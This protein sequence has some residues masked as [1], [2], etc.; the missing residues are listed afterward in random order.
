MKT[1]LVLLTALALHVSAAP[2]SATLQK[3]LDA[4]GN[5]QNFVRYDDDY[6]YLGF[7]AYKRGFEDPRL[8][9]PARV[10]AVPFADPTKKIKLETLD[11]AVDAITVDGTLYILTF[12]GIEE[13]DARTLTRRAVHPTYLLPGE[14]AYKEHAQAF[15]RAGDSLVI[16]HQLLGVSFFNL[17]SKR[18][19]HQ[20]RLVQRQAPHESKATAVTVDGKFAY[21][22]LDEHT[23]NPNGKPAFRGVVVIDTE[24]KKVVSE[25]D[26]M[27]PGADAVATDGKTLIVSF[28]GMPLWKY[29]LAELKGKALPRATYHWKFPIPGHPTGKPALDAKFYYTCYVKTPDKPQG[30]YERFAT[31][32]ERSP[33]GLD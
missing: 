11:G 29:S 6:L 30:T 33:M 15:A 9:I 27:D 21:V 28:M 24:T 17:K 5:C 14:R 2:D 1:I 22:I 13:W 18:I 20:F 25:L 4:A 3:T 7:G 8:P 10:T 26:G 12:T 32:L 31:A 16:A 23:L 19:T